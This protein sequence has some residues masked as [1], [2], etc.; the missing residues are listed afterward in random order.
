MK[1]MRCLN[2]SLVPSGLLCS[3]D[4]R[5]AWSGR[6]ERGKRFQH[7][8]PHKHTLPNNT[9]TS[10]SSPL[11]RSLFSIVSI[12]FNRTPRGWREQV[13]KISHR[14]NHKIDY[15]FTRL[16]SSISSFACIHSLYY[17]G[18]VQTRV[19][20][21]THTTLRIITNYHII[22]QEIVDLNLHDNIPSSSDTVF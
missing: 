14:F 12:L 6:T 20:C 19:N 5:C 2:L 18:T 3:H 13:R 11:S 16:T 22:L 4:R 17:V 8:W 1:D 9:T 15:W 10:S 7:F 21:D